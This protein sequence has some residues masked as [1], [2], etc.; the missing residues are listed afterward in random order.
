MIK[1]MSEKDEKVKYISF[2]RNFGKESA[3]YAGMEYSDGDYV[4]IMDVDLQDPPALIPKSW[5]K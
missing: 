2:S 3:M 4:V 1:D 5:R